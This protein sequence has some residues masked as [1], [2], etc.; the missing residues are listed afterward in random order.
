M[1]VAFHDYFIIVVG[2]AVV[3]YTINLGRWFLRRDKKLT[4]WS[5]FLLAFLVIITALYLL[6]FF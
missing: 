2:L 3:I 4:A 1:G 5:T 6:A